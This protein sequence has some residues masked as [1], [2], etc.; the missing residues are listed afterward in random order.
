LAIFQSSRFQQKELFLDM[1]LTDRI[2]INP[3]VLVGKPVIKGTRISVEMIL[4]ELGAGNSI[5][6]LLENYPRLQK[7]DILAAL[8]YSALSLKRTIVYPASA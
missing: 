1:K 8:Q 2:E 3:G 4:E 5:E 7:E 6:D